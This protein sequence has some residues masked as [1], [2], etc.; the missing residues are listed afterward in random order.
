M[1][2]FM[3]EK[4]VNYWIAKAIG[5]HRLF[6]TRVPKTYASGWLTQPQEI[7]N[8]RCPGSIES[9]RHRR[10][11]FYAQG[12]SPA[13]PSIVSGFQGTW[14]SPDNLYPFPNDRFG[15]LRDKP[16]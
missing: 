16:V 6:A 2:T 5:L 4:P 8:Q 11:R 14:L 1:A 3:E 9:T 10:K 12:D 15:C 7:R 13:Q